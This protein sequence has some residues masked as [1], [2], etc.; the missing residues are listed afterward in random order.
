MF[1]M[2]SFINLETLCSS[3]ALDSKKIIHHKQTK[4]KLNC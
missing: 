4:I 3:L 1:L 2:I